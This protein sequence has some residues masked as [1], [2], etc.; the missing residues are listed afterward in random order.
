[1]VIPLILGYNLVFG[2]GKILHF[3]QEGI[4]IVAAYAVWIPVMQ[5]GLPLPVGIAIG[6]VLSIGTALLLAWLS[7]RLDADGLGVMSIALHLALLAVVLN[8]QSLTRGALGIPRIPMPEIIGDLWSLTIFSGIIAIIW[9]VGIYLL[10]RGAFGRALTALAEDEEHAESLG[11]S[12]KKIHIIAFVIAG[13]GGLIPNI[14]IPM[15]LHLLSPSD[16]AFPFMI[17][18]IMIVIAGGP[19]RV[20]GVVIATFILYFLKEGIRFVPLP[21]NILGP[22]R[23]VLFGLILFTAVWIRR[24]SIFPPQRKI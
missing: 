22:M 16:F 6:T 13:V 18:F 14:M 23:Q 3:G 19:G 24:D 17:F 4:S 7:F 15:Y 11:I 20:W 9:I 1:M 2:K 10:D 8:W 12:K 21:A 5:Y